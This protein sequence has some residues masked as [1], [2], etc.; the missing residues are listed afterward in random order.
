MAL[1]P[2]ASSYFG[3][4]HLAILDHPLLNAA[5]DI[6]GLAQGPVS[7]EAQLEPDSLSKGWRI[8]CAF[9]CI[10]YLDE[11][12]AAEFPQ[13][14]R[15]R[16][17]GLQPAT[18]ATVE[19]VEGELEVG[20]SLG[21][22]PWQ[23]PHNDQPSG[24]TLLNGGMGHLIDTSVGD[25]SPQQL[26]AMGTE[27]MIVTLD[28]VDGDLLAT[29]E[30]YVIGLIPGGRD[31]QE[32]AE[33]VQRAEGTPEFFAARAYC[34]GGRIGVDLPLPGA[35]LFAP[36]IPALRV[37]SERAAISAPAVEGQPEVWEVSLPAADFAASL[38][39]GSRRP[40]RAQASPDLAALVKAMPR[41]DKLSWRA[42]PTADVPGRFS[43]ESARV[44][45]RRQARENGRGGHHRR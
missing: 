27:Q 25:L 17:S 38:P 19:I 34:A 1:Y 23:V 45:A 13:L 32:V 6:P 36:S 22:G 35:E 40:T 10:G 7:L 2:L 11:L 39:H 3:V 43:S 21:L 28:S 5:L 42:L 9:G 31:L 14:A 24:S 12:E 30:G 20:V 41:Q 33:M 37:P 29:A 16:A 15:V 26:K 18:V 4:E 8:R 44:R